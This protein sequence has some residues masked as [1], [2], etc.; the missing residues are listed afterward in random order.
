MRKPAVALIAFAIVAPAAA[1][2]V[3]GLE[4]C[5]AE[6]AMERRTGCLQSNIEFLQQALAKHARET[7]AALDAA[8]REAAAQKAEV[9]TQKNEIAAL[10]AELAKLQH[11]LAELKKPKPEKK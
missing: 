8:K 4:V 11:E 2:D 5:T 1:Q 6:K 3:R 7:K 10:K 9:A